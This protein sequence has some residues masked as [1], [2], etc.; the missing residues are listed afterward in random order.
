MNYKEE[1]HL[2]TIFKDTK[3][4]WAQPGFE[5]GTSCT[6]SRNHTPR[7]LSHLLILFLFKG[8]ISL[9]FKDFFLP[10]RK[11]H[12]FASLMHGVKW[13]LHLNQ[14]WFPCE[15][16]VY[17]N[18]YHRSQMKSI[19]TEKILKWSMNFSIYSKKYF[20]ISNKSRIILIML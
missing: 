5:P 11:H 4:W 18:Q 7:P 10:M 8:N 16:F 17:D 1:M 19:T 14:N 13:R 20:L 15:F 12:W 9:H 2:N 6:Q 3:Y